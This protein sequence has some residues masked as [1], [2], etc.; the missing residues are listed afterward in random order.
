MDEKNG[1]IKTAYM[2]IPNLMPFQ[3]EPFNGDTFL[4]EKFLSLRDS[5]DIKVAIELG[6]CL[7]STAL[8]LAQHFDAVYTVEINEEYASI[9]TE[10][11]GMKD[12]VTL[13]VRNSLDALPLILPEVTNDTIIF[14]DSHWGANNPLLK[15]LKLIKEHGLRPIIVIHDMKVPGRPELGYD[16]YPQEN[17][18]YEFEWIRQSIEDIYGKDGFAYYYN[19]DAAGAKR[20]CIF[21]L[22]L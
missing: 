21:I 6:T 8:W 18:V 5:Y 16:E 10:R 4:Q 12:N 3:M 11:I 1:T 2:N 14:I 7:G 22:P 15:E 20:G 9:A 17:I 13:Y 19:S